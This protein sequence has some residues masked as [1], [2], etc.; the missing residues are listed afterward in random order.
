MRQLTVW[1]LLGLLLPAAAFA[2]IEMKVAP[3]KQDSPAKIYPIDGTPLLWEKDQEVAKFLKENP[4]YLT[5]NRLK[6]VQS[7]GFSVGSQK[8]FYTYDFTGGSPYQSNFTCRAIGPHSY[9]FVEDSLWGSRVNQAAVDSVL[10]AFENKT[11]ANPNKGIYQMDVDAFGNP[12]DV[13]NDPRIIILILNIKDGFNGSGGYTAGYFASANEVPKGTSGSI[14][15]D[16]AEIYYVDAN[17]TNLNTES[18]VVLAMSTTAHEFQHMIQWNYNKSRLTF[19]NES[20]SMLAEINCGYP[21]FDQS[22][23]ENETNHFLF[24]WRRNDNTKVLIDYS[25]AQRFSLYYW[26]QFGIGIFKYL[27]QSGQDGVYDYSNALT[28][29]GQSISFQNTFINW[30]VANYLNDKSVNP[31]YGYSYPNLYP[32]QSK[33]YY[34]PNASGGTT[35]AGLGADYITFNGGSDL[36]ITFTSSGTHLVIKAIK[37]GSGGNVVDDVPIGSAYSV[38]DYG[39]TYSTVTFAIINTRE[40]GI[41]ES[42]TFQSTGT[43]P[44]PAVQEMKWDETEPVGYLQL[45]RGDSAAVQFEGFPGAKLDSIKVALRGT[46]SLAGNIYNFQ[47]NASHL[48]TTKLASFTA[49]PTVSAPPPVVD[50]TGDYPYAKPYPNWVKV[51]LSSQNIDASNPFVVEFPIG[52]SYPTTNRVMVTYYQSSGSYHSFS[53]AS[54]NNPPVWTFYGVSGKSGYIFLYLVRA[55][56]TTGVTGIEQ[57][58][59]LT[60]KNFALSQNYPN[61]FNPST[62]IDFALPKSEKVTVRIF[63]QLGQQVATLADRDFSAGNHKLNFDG[64][65]LS[66]GI[67]YYRIEAGSFTQTKKMILMK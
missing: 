56:V 41:G 13:D 17:P 51:D 9:I 37:E 48:G 11:P 12:P 42:Y 27:V 58:I 5:K 54:S 6:K 20:N 34:T 57:T 61:P 45:T 59:E 29:T 60:P 32:A 65:N 18:G 40:D 28:Q 2:Q 64:A 8:A 43:G 50:T 35:V 26:E 23:Y 15:N 24:D 67:Y 38:P 19:I 52:A 39:T 53:Y 21:I 22:L 4:D 46:T 14:G 16:A 49:V 47:N 66:S 33:K 3:E 44:A 63:N 25:R 7:W 31:A 55:Y 36:N 62:T 30:E 1:L 10:N